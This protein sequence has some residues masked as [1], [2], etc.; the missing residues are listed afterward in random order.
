MDHNNLY[1]SKLS[2]T[3]IVLCQPQLPENVG[4]A[5]RAMLNFGFTRLR[6]VSE[7]DFSLDK[8]CSLSSGEY[9]HLLETFDTFVTLEAAITDMHQV[10]A[11]SARDR[12]MSTI[13]SHLQHITLHADTKY[14]FVFG[15]EKNGLSNEELSL[16]SHT[17]RLPTSPQCSSMNLSHAV[18]VVC[19]Q[20]SQNICSHLDD[21]NRY[22][23]TT[24]EKIQRSDTEF[25]MRF[26]ESELDRRSHFKDQYKKDNM[27]QTLRI[28]FEKAQLSQQEYRS[29]LGALRTLTTL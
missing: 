13:S 14:A 11:L 21:I 23:S 26:L 16:C 6:I 18:S 29:L 19:Y 27:I 12:H 10:Y 24:Q 1:A 3:Y 20:I 22:I 28:I 8:Q 15:C 7:K 5:I 2:Q 17:V 9:D 25:L 4:M